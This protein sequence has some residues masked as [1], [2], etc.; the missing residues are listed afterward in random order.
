M[1]RHDSK[2]LVSLQ[3][4]DSRQYFYLFILWP[5]L[6]LITA[7][8]NYNQKDSRRVVYLFLVYYGLTFVV[9]NVGVDAERNALYL[10]NI[11]ELPFSDFFKIIGGIYSSETSVDIVEQLIY[12]IVSRF[13]SHHSILF[14][15]YAGIFGYFYLKSIDLLYDRYQKKPGRNVLIHMVFFIFI[16]P[17]T[18]INGFRMWTAAWIFF[19]GAYHVILYRDPKYFIVTIASCFVHFSFLSIN[20]ILLI[21]YFAGN[22]NSIYLPIAIISFILPRFIAPLIQSISASLGGGL[23]ARVEMYTDEAYASGVKDSLQQ[24]AWFMQIGNDLVFYYLVLAIIFI[25]LQRRFR[26]IG[27]EEKNLFS[28][29]LLLIAFV[30]FGKEIPSFGVRFQVIFFM[31]AT[32]YLILYF[33]KLKQNQVSLVTLVG[34]FP[35]LLKA[36]ISFRQGSDSINAWIFTPGLGVPLFFPGLSIADLLF[37]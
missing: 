13:T 12:Y 31:F 18:A 19:Y 9:G 1:I 21:Y 16:L 32:L 2:Q 11:A 29:L 17:I 24:V 25:Q 15:V 8:S 3:S 5:F 37:Y 23:K 26:M 4:A 27:S 22:R 7:L 36:A 20:A 35:M 34:L 30:N 33:L 6:A 14:A 10:K 28:F